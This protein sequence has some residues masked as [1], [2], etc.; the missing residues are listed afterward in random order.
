MVLTYSSSIDAV[1]LDFTG[2]MQAYRFAPLV[3]KHGA[4]DFSA[5]SIIGTPD[6]I[7]KALVFVKVKVALE[8]VIDSII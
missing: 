5:E 2:F 3:R 1:L 8:D 4:C 7:I 6:E